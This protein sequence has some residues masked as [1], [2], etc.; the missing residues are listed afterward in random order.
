[1]VELVATA[2]GILVIN[3]LP[4][5][6]YLVGLINCEISSLW[7]LEAVKAQA[8]V[9]RTYAL[10]QKRTRRGALYDVESTVL[11]QVYQGCMLEDSR[12][13]RAVQETAGEVLLYE[14]KPVQAFYHSTCGGHTELP[15]N[16][17]GFSL[18]YLIDRECSYCSTAPSY[19]WEQRL[20][21]PRIEAALR[22]Q[23]VIE[24][25]L[26][27]VKEGR[28]SRGGRLV[29]LTIVD[30]RG[31]RAISAP[32]FRKAMG[33]DLLP[34]TAFT[35]QRT[36]EELLFK[37]EGKGHGVGL[38]QWGA[39][40]QAQEGRSYRQILAYYYHDVCLTRLYPL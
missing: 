10:F 21:L 40:G 5:E 6:E 29:E 4:L 34:S 27:S 12:A 14:G 16:V 15:E 19:R 26:S 8:V 38:C 35:I 32:L 28:R 7:P 18:P 36:G 13:V 9:A 22:R 11:D 17:W 3:D 2:D 31:A 1:V 33:Y 37:G 24:G 25:H 39:N 20:S 30:G 23:G